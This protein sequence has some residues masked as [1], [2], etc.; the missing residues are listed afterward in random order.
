MHPWAFL[1]KK[2]LTSNLKP[3]IKNIKNIIQSSSKNTIVLKKEKQRSVSDQFS[4]QEYSDPHVFL[5]VGFIWL[6]LCETIIW[7]HDMLQV[8]V[9]F[10]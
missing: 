6:L 7:I 5:F 9:L 1:K 10:H 8:F 2:I 4:N 3:F